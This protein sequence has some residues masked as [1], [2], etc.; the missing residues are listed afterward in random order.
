MRRLIREQ[1]GSQTVEYLLVTPL[2]IA[3][4]AAVLGQLTLAAIGLVTC[5][6]A[7]RDAAIAAARGNDPLL[8]A[9]Q[10]AP[11]WELRVSPPRP[12]RSGSYRGVQ[13]TVTM[14]VPAL[15]L[16]MLAGK[17]FTIQRTATMPVETG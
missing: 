16:R 1:R 9:R 4:I 17:G 14:T 11:D 13:V 12:V 6:A 10:A 15:P 5:E 2:A 7:A 8:A 3:L